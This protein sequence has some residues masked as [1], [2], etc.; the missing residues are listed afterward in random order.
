MF[1][2]NLDE[3]YFDKIDTEAKAYFLGLLISDG[4][5]CHSKKGRA[6]LVCLTLKNED[7]Y[8]LEKFVNEINSNKNVTSDG[9]G[10][11]NINISSRIMVNDLKK[12]GV[13]ENKSLKTIF[14]KNIPLE[15][16]NHLIRGILDGDGSISYYTRPSKKTHIKAVRF[17]Q[18]NK[19]FLQDLVDFLY[20]AVDIPKI[21]VYQEKDSLWSVAYRK[22]T[23]VIKLIYYMYNNAN[24]YMKRKKKLCDLVYAEAIERGNTEITVKPKNLIA[25]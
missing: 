10:C 18:G 2:P 1:S 16:Y 5:V 6:P 25:S 24:I 23:S 12:Y 7:S 20:E 3:H 19:D 11:S 17:C 14:P 21:N 9:R 22:N 8:L 4:C 15:M 13:I